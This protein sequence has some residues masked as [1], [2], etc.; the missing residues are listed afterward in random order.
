VTGTDVLLQVAGAA[1]LF[2]TSDG[3][4]F[5]DLM[6]EGHRETW[7]LRSNRFRA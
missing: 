3:V 4:A 6:I 2:H 1:G 5:A 7:P